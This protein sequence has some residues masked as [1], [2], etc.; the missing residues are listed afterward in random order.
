MSRLVSNPNPST[1]GTL[2]SNVK[3]DLAFSGLFLVRGLIEDA[4]RL[5]VAALGGDLNISLSVNVGTFWQAM[6]LLVLATWAIPLELPCP[7]RMPMFCS[8]VLDL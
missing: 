3:A 1:F 5:N 8:I 2:D 7:K 6:C 4:E